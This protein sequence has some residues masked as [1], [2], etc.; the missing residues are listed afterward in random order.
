MSSALQSGCS[1]SMGS[2]HIVWLQ[3]SALQLCMLHRR[4]YELTWSA[5]THVPSLE[6]SMLS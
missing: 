2:E 6:C 5:L 3:T 4:P 1:P